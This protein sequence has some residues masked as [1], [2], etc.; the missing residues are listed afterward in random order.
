MEIL[1]KVERKIVLRVVEAAS[2]DPSIPLLD[3]GLTPQDKAALTRAKI[4]LRK[5]LNSKE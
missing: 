1:S 3:L 5:N 4:K 2:M